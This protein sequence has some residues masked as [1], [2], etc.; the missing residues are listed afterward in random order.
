MARKALLVFF[1]MFLAAA[2]AFGQ[3]AIIPQVPADYEIEDV[4]TL[5]QDFGLSAGFGSEACLDTSCGNFFVSEFQRRYYS[6][7]KAGKPVSDLPRAVRIMK[8]HA[9]GEW[10]GEN[11]RK[12]P[13]R[14][15][16]ELLTN[17]DLDRFPSMNRAAVVVAPAAMRVLPAKRPFFEKPDGF[18]FDILQNAG[19][20]MNEPIRVLHVSRDGVWVFAETADANGW[21]EARDIGY[22]DESLIARRMGKAEIVIVRDRTPIRD[23]EGV[24]TRLAGVGTLFPILGEDAMCYEVN[25]AA[26]FGGREAREIRVRVPKG[27]ARRF[28]LVCSGE[29]VN[30]IG[31][32]LIGKPY[33]WGEM[34]QGRDCS[35]LIRD[36]FVPFG[37]WLPRGSYMQITSGKRIFLSSLNPAEKEGYIRKH[38]IPF[39][40]LLHLKGHIMLYIGTMNDRALAFHSLWGVTVRKF[41][42]GT[43]KQVVGKSVISTLTPGSELLLANG[44]ILD[45]VDS[46]LI[47]TDRCPR[48]GNSE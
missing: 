27:S 28:P 40:T 7:W 36:F 45:R 48:K 23:K 37:I 14:D 12:I 15:L 18:P 32:E 30:L 2:D 11:L 13:R 6:P 10:Y 4:R 46:M 1:A 42:G 17:C 9:Q 47:L 44:S 19:L 21:V 24:T 25:A 43:A 26:T 3:Q 31:N 8:E 39:L 38:G 20:K 29:N 22:V 33:G 35:S 41:D 5:P 34:Y 16:D